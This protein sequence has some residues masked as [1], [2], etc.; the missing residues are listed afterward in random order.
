M[1][2]PRIRGKGRKYRGGGGGRPWSLQVTRHLP[3]AL[4]LHGNSMLSCRVLRVDGRDKT[5]NG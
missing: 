1:P 5:N 2:G 3:T 4:P